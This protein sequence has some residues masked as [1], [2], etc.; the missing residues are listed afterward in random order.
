[1]ISS[2]SAQPAVTSAM[3]V[4]K[5][6]ATITLWPVREMPL[7]VTA[8]A[9][10]ER[11]VVGGERFEPGRIDA[12][13]LDVGALQRVRLV[14]RDLGRGDRDHAGMGDRDCERRIAAA[15]H[16]QRRQ[17]DEAHH[18][19]D[20]IV[21]PQTCR[22]VSRILY[23]VSFDRR[24][25]IQTGLAMAATKGRTA[26]RSYALQIVGQDA[27]PVALGARTITVGAHA[28]CDLVL[29]DAQVSRESM[30]SSRSRRRES[31]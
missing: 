8:R 27:P 18:L 30:R 13:E 21:S 1:M 14:D 11:D 7:E 17:H 12:R 9:A 28:T 10:V 3:F 23:I 19:I 20:R 6:R 16:D 24:T 22:I 25:L 15:G 29:T 31:A 26:P 4:S 5:P 2:F